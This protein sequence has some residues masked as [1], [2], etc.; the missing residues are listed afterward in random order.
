MKFSY[1]FCLCCLVSVWNSVNGDNNNAITTI[2]KHGVL[3]GIDRN[4]F[5][6]LTVNPQAL[7]RLEISVE[8]DLLGRFKEDCLKEYIY[9]AFHFLFCTFFFIS[10][11]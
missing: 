3:Y 4:V 2:T 8:L 11:L 6:K 7:R 9:F 1:I 5:Y 10:L